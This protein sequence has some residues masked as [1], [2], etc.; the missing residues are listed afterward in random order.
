MAGSEDFEIAG[1]SIVGKDHLFSRKNNQDAYAFWQD[2]DHIVGI[3]ADGCGS[4]P[5]SEWGARYGVNMLMNNIKHGIGSYRYFPNRNVEMFLPQISY[6]KYDMDR[7]ISSMAN[8]SQDKIIEDHLLFTLMG[9]IVAPEE[10]IVFAI[11]D[12]VYIVNGN[13]VTVSFKGNAPLYLAYSLL[14]WYKE[15]MNFKILHTIPTEE[16]QTLIV[17]TD[18]LTDFTPEDPVDQFVE[19][20]KYFKNPDAIRRK[21][22]LLNQTRYNVDWDNRTFDVNN[23]LLS[24]DTTLIALRRKKIV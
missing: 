7:M 12:G 23:G 19:Q 24:D 9:F 2:E 17:G 22:F 14:P 1:G 4:S 5:Y 6:L 13:P 21:L 3:V 10:T 20:D 15:N 11:G 16:L 18:G 8:T